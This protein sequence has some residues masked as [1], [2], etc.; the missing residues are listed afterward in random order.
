MFFTT[1]GIAV[2]RITTTSGNWGDPTYAYH[3]TVQGVIQPFTGDDSYKTGQV[4]ENVRDLITL[5]TGTDILK[6]DVLYYGA[7]WHRVQYIQNW[8]A[9][10]LPHIEA[11]TTDSQWRPV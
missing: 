11:Y 6:E 10:I 2:Y 9:G 3:H 8:A 4:F 1:S 7:D 5:A